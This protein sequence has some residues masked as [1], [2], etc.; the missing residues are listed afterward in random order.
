[1]GHEGLLGE[2]G[3][4]LWGIGRHRWAGWIS[5]HPKSPGHQLTPHPRLGAMAPLRWQLHS[6]GAVLGDSLPS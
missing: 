2:P 3:V 5:E 1:M 4:S 6:Q